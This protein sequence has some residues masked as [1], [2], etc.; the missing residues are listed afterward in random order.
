LKIL[1]LIAFFYSLISAFSWKSNGSSFFVFNFL[2]YV[3]SIIYIFIDLGSNIDKR[4]SGQP[5][6]SGL[7]DQFDTSWLS[8]LLGRCGFLGLTNLFELSSSLD[9]YVSSGHPSLSGSSGLPDP[10]LS[11]DLLDP[12]V[13]S[14]RSDISGSFGQPSRSW[15]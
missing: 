14:G 6:P 2:T 1:S 3:V 9:R 5:C 13:S 8:G 10:F 7:L 11:S 4:L 12:F 15:L